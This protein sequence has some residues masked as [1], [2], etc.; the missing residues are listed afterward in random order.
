VQ[1]GDLVLEQEME[2][3]IAGDVAGDAGAHRAQR[4]RHRHQHRRV[5]AHAEIVVRAP[6]GDLGADAVMEGSREISAA[7]LEIGTAP[8][9]GAHSDAL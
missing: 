5:L 7:P 3:I 1:I 6:D 4:L 2:M 8:R 9:R